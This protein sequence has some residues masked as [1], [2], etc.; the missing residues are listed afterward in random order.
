MKKL[1]NQPTGYKDYSPKLTR[2]DTLT[3]ACILWKSFWQAVCRH[4]DDRL[5]RLS[6]LRC[7]SLRSAL[8]TLLLAPLAAPAANPPAN[9]VLIYADDLG[10]G[11]VGC[12]GATKIK[13]PNIDRL[14]AEGRLFTDAHSPSAV[15]TPSRYGLLTGRYPHRERLFAPI[16]SDSPLCIDPESVTLADVF[17][18]AGYTTACVG[19]W[20]LGFGM[21]GMPDWNGEVKPGPLEL[22]FDYFFGVPV[23]NSHPPFFLMEGHRVLG[24]DPADPLTWKRGAP[25]LNTR[26]FPEKVFN[27]RQD[28]F[29]FSGGKSAHDLYDD[30]Q[31]MTRLTEEA[32]KV[33]V[34]Q[35]EKSFFLY[36]ATTAIHHP[37][38]PHPRFKG[39][40]EAGLYGD[41]VHELDWS[42]GEIL[43]A[44]EKADVADRTLVLLTSDN[45]G[46]AN[47]AG[48]EALK[49]GHRLNG[50][51][52][53]FKFGAWEG[54]H[55]VPFIARWPGRIPAGTKSDQLISSIDLIRTFA[56]L[57]GQKL[58]EGSAL[59]SLDILPALTGSPE[60]PVREELVI[61]PREPSHVC[62]RQGDWVFIPAQGAG[63][64]RGN[65]GHS[66]AGNINSDLTPDGKVKPGAPPEQLYNLKT[67]PRQQVN[68]IDQHPEM[69]G[70][71]RAHLAEFAPSRKP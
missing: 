39:T 67:D 50:D 49:R 69:A 16:W 5:R 8:A 68:V 71:L 23:V 32:V 45:G 37:F 55:R 58:S 17:H 64:F 54:G 20:H 35:K 33:I 25:N 44:I 7:G 26:E 56:G 29:G 63:G 11:D 22:G 42:V 47:G 18:N 34:A 2:K 12:Y 65:P 36:F 40:S 57:L 27:A 59:D 60:K 10:Y 28:Q 52:Q 13:T 1:I 15:C 4:F 31:L 6:S 41:F 21:G 14:A 24:L 46:M 19:K 30:E 3:I 66:K 9:V 51:L 43:A 61:G 48:I 53:G 38:T 62:L 70:R